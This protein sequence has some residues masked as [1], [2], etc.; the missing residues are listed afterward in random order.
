[1][2][3]KNNQIL[4]YT[5]DDGKVDIELRLDPENQTIWLTQPQMAKLFDIGVNTIN[6]HIS[7]IYRE[8]ELQENGTIRYY[9]IVQREGQRDIER[10]V[11]HYNLKLILAVGYRIRSHRGTQFRRWA[12]EHLNEY[13]I[14]GFVL[15]DKKLK[16]PD[17]WDYFDELLEQIRDIRS[18][19]KRFYLKVKDLFRQTSID[20]DK[21]D[22]RAQEFF[23]TI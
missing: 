3:V 23:A 20:Y 9:R 4:L 2:E 8:E 5:T 11:I 16:N 13:L 1:M 19:E 17:V 15:N 22:K 18:S 12:T 10:E 7:N 21:R 6:H 14:K